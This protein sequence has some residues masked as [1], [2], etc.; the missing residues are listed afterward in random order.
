MK[1]IL[2]IITLC[3]VA[4]TGCTS[5]MNAST[6]KFGDDLVFVKSGDTYIIDLENS[7]ELVK[8]KREEVLQ[9]LVDEETLGDVVGLTTTTA[10]IFYQMGI[11]PVGAPESPSLNME[12][13]SQQYALE[14][15]G[16]IDKSRVLNVG[17][18]LAPNVEAIIELNPQLALY[19]SAMPKADYV[20]NLEAGGVNVSSIG[21]SDY[22]DMFVLLDVVNELTNFENSQSTE[23]MNSMVESLKSTLEIIENA[24]AEEKTVAILLVTEGSIN[25]NNDATVLGQVSKALGMKNVFADSE[26]A[27]LNKEQLLTLNPDYIIYYSHGMGTEAVSNF[28]A[29]LTSDTSIYRELDAVKNGQAFQV[30]SEDFVFSSSVDFN[31]IEVIKFLAEKFYA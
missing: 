24:D 29:E 28:E 13:A 20:A 15:T 5:S 17:S 22:I 23:L 8:S 7:T 27:E 31:I 1:R 11:M 3:L 26:N 6:V 30:A 12:I 4:L 14:E 18:A 16:A 19:S 25:V 21:Q 9:T 10:N 2:L